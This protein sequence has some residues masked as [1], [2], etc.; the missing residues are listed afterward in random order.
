MSSLPRKIGHFKNR[1]FGC[2]LLI[3]NRRKDGEEIEVYRGT[4]SFCVMSVRDQHP[5]GRNIQANRSFTGRHF[6][7][8]RKNTVVLGVP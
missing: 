6:S 7:I 8:G 4:D 2:E 5:S 1:E 3:L